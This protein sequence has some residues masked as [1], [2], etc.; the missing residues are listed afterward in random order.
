MIFN[1]NNVYAENARVGTTT[2][3][4][5]ATT[6]EFKYN[7]GECH[8]DYDITISYGGVNYAGYCADFGAHL[9]TYYD[10]QTGLA[11]V[12]NYQCT[13]EENTQI[14]SILGASGYTQSEK[15]AA[16]RGITAGL[17][18]DNQKVQDLLNG[19]SGTS[20]LSL[21]KIG[22]GKNSVTYSINTSLDMSKVSF[23]CG[24]GCSNVSVSGKTL[25]V[26]L[27]NGACTFNITATYPGSTNSSNT[28]NSSIS[29]GTTTVTTTTKILHCVNDYGQ[30]VYGVY[31]DNSSSTTPPTS[32]P[33][34]G[35]PGMVTQ[36]FSGSLDRCNEE[37]NK[38]NQQTEFNIP[39]YCDDAGDKQITIT[40]P[41]DVKYC[42]LNGKDEAGNTYKMTDGQVKEDNPYCAVYCK[43]DYK[44]T[45]PGAKYSDSGRYFELQ[46]T[47]VE[48]TRTCYATNTKGNSD[49]PAIDIE[50]FIT[51]VKAKQIRVIQAYDEY[52][53]AEKE[54]KLAKDAE[55]R[56]D[57]DPGCKG[58]IGPNYKSD[59]ESY[60][61]ARA[62]C[63]DTTGKCEKRDE[64][65]E[66]D[67][68][69]WGTYNTMEE[70][71]NPNVA[72]YCNDNTSN[73]DRPDF[74]GK[75]TQ[76]KNNIIDAVNDLKRTI[77]HMEDCYNW[78][79]NLCLDTLVNF[80]YEEQYSTNINYELV[81]GG[82]TFV[83][84]D[85]TY[86]N[87]KTIDNAYTTNNGENLENV[88]YVYCDENGCNNSN[89]ATL[90]EKI[91]TL[92]THQYFRKIEV[93]GNAEYANTQKFQTNY[94]SGTIDTVADQSAIR[95][96]YSYLGTVF[97][98]ALNTP[99]GVYNW[100]LNFTKLGQ[101]NEGT[102]CRNGRL[103]D[104][105]KALGKSASAGIEYVCVYIVDCPDC[106]YECIDPSGNNCIIPDPEPK[107][108]DCDVYCTNCIFNGEATYEYRVIG[109][110]VNPNER[111]QGAN[112]E[113]EKGQE[114]IKEIE[115]NGENIYI[116]AEYTYVMDASNMKAIRDYNKK[117][118]TYVAEDLTFH[119]AEGI[120]NAYGTSSFLDNGQK[121]GFF[122][123]KKRNKNWTQW[124]NISD[125]I[126]P[127]W[128]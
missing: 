72:Y 98:V 107:C 114:T 88:N 11:N 32:T 33:N 2:S 52:K 39:A 8:R 48:A 64:T 16:L 63:N 99:Y 17:T 51:D 18:T 20:A 19:A 7:N 82:G 5:D 9:D 23:T 84:K 76:A 113:N 123:E 104:V 83:G 35:T 81:V 12:N 75:V 122:T 67:S 94:P 59:S 29:G 73:V 65:H 95:Y 24:S 78:T 109:S 89:S 70:P 54:L 49:N 15:T 112:W 14:S 43:E 58:K 124:T 37:P 42:I 120:A 36:N 121:N 56:P 40:A 128:K 91:S 79:N 13:V 53:K 46:N 31:N 117:T 103:D 115:S 74:E 125:N 66:T 27:Q 68:Y 77:E 21:I 116:D 71:D 93:K 57:Y 28:T 105:A 34:P 41:N 69:S 60:V 119:D 87:A 126:G 118:G 90:A 97:P 108:D 22:E 10:Q 100:T 111:K 62:V 80:D 101:Y 38:C 25:T 26:Q 127:A 106:D 4:T 6:C 92:A 3:R 85:A 61:G 47:V 96:N 86:S 30:E 45:M 1:F 50:Q 110:E 102:G 44:M 55:G